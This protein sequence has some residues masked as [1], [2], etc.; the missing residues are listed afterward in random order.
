MTTRHDPPVPTLWNLATLGRCE[1]Y[2]RRTGDFEEAASLNHD[3]CW[4]ERAHSSAEPSNR[5]VCRR[6]VTILSGCIFCVCSE[7]GNK[8]CPKATDH[9]NACTGSNEPGQLGSV[10]E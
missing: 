10:Y 5:C 1:R 9:D 4:I 8:R 7:C 3:V 6:C 2:A